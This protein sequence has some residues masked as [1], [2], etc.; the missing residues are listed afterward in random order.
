MLE[1]MRRTRFGWGQGDL[2]RLY[3]GYGFAVIEGAR[4][5]VI[6]HPE[7]PDLNTTVARHD[8][9]DPAYART[10][11]LLI[12]ELVRRRAGAGGGESAR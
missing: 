2:R 6:R 9:L 4:H 11:I 10:A 1:R 8:D 5:I 7:Y 3:R 12:D